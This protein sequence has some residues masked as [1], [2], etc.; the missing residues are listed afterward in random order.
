MSTNSKNNFNFFCHKCG[1]TT[2]IYDK[3]ASNRHPNTDINKLTD[4]ALT[5]SKCYSLCFGT[6]EIAL[7]AHPFYL[8]KGTGL[9]ILLVVLVDGF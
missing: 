4:T 1:K 3:Q 2:D 9:P 5:S 8:L 7:C 6:E